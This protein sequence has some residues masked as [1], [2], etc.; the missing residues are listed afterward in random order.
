[1]RKAID[2]YEQGTIYDM[3]NANK[4]TPSAR[5]TFV[6]R[7]RADIARHHE[8]ALKRSLENLAAI[9]NSH[10]SFTVSVLSADL[11]VLMDSTGVRDVRV[12]LARAM[13]RKIKY[14]LAI[15]DRY[16]ELDVSI[17]AQM[18]LVFSDYDMFAGEGDV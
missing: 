11:L 6:E 10:S 16:I 17:K 15:L 12:A 18:A 2:E 5:L 3:T 8:Y 14:H 13:M 9:I 4:L 7:R 1:M